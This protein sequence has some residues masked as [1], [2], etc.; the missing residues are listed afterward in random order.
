MAW[1][2]TSDV[3]SFFRRAKRAIRCRVFSSSRS[4]RGDA[5]LSLWRKFSVLQGV[6][7]GEAG[8]YTH[9]RLVAIGLHLTGDFAPHFP[10]DGQTGRPGARRATRAL[11]PRETLPSRQPRS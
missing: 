3:V 11:R 2:K 6:I 4:V 9:G 1:R 5:M 7:Q 10:N 8:N